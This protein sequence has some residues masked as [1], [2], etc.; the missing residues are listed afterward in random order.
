MN[1]GGRDNL[2]TKMNA[3]LNDFLDRAGRSWTWPMLTK[4]VVEIPLVAGVGFVLVGAGAGGID[5]RVTHLLGQ[6]ILYSDATLRRLRG[7]PT[8]VDFIDGYSDAIVNAGGG[9]GIPDQYTIDTISQDQKRLLF[10][11][12]ASEDL[13]I[14][15]S[16]HILYDPLT[17]G[18]EIPWYPEDETMIQ[19]V[20]AATLRSENGVDSPSYRA[21]LDELGEMMGND[22]IRHGASS[23]VNATMGM[24]PSVFR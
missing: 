20:M 21:A 17:T 15:M 14:D 23:T 22:K 6:P 2:N 3:A 12:A 18:T 5:E 24:D 4:R 1:R 19:A 8:L 11:R 16:V 9:V 13:L 10:N 7:R